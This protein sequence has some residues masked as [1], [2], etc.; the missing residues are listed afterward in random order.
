MVEPL[1][2]K[3]TVAG[4]IPVGST[5]FKQEIHRRKLRKFASSKQP[6]G[7]LTSL[8]PHGRCNGNRTRVVLPNDVRVPAKTNGEIKQKRGY[9]HLKIVGDLVIIRVS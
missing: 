9:V 5:T 2:L 6:I 8:I 4:S 3:E 1:P 7:R